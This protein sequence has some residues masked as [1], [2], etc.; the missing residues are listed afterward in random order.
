MEESSVASGDQLLHVRVARIAQEQ[1]TR[2]C[3]YMHDGSSHSHWITYMKN[4]DEFMRCLFVKGSDRAVVLV[5]I[6]PEGVH[7]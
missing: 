5:S 7:W 2:A 6:F 1:P 4:L 3:L